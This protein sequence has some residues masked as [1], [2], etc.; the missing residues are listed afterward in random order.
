MKKFITMLP[1]M[2]CAAVFISIAAEPHAKI[3]E[4]L[5]PGLTLSVAETQAVSV[6][7]F[8]IVPSFDGI[9]T[10]TIVRAF[11]AITSTGKPQGARYAFFRNNDVFRLCAYHDEFSNQ[12]NHYNFFDNL[13]A[14]TE[15]RYSNTLKQYPTQTAN[16]NLRN[17]RYKRE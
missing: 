4:E 10:V 3:V 7:D 1:L 5:P 15:R 9:Q 16:A 12:T 13:T 6:A 2:L 11:A 17:S 8:A 14:Y